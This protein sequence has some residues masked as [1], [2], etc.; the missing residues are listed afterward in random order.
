MSIKPI[1]EWLKVKKQDNTKKTVGQE[2]VLSY[3]DHMLTGI[4]D[5]VGYHGRHWWMHRLAKWNDEYLN[6]ILQ[7]DPS[8]SPDSR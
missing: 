7:R 1:V 4:E 5:I 2:F 6:P 3:M 8:S